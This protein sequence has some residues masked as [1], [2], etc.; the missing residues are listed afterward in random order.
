MDYFITHSMAFVN[1]S[2]TQHPKLDIVNAIQTTMDKHLF[3]CG[4]LIDLKIALVQLIM[5]HY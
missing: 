3:S 5:A 1:H 2:S 4:I